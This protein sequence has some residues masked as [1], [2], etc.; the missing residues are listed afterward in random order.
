MKRNEAVQKLATVGR[1]SMAH[2][3]DLY[4]SIIPKPVVPKYVADWYEENK[5]DFEVNLFNCIC[6]AVENY[7]GSSSN[8]F[9]NWLMSKELEVIQTLVNMHQFGYE[10]EEEPRYTV[11]IKGFDDDDTFLNYNTD[12]DYWFL[13]DD[14]RTEEVRVAHTRKELEEA[15]FGWVF[16]CPGVEVKE[17]E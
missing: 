1:L 11:E 8:E 3:E 13:E 10:V 15:D 7:A 12:W 9:E 4:D 6:E 14:K 2:A 17:V 5:D 16:D